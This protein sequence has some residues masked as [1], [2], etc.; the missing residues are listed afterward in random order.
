MKNLFIVCVIL[1]S[2]NAFSQSFFGQ[3]VERLHFGVKAGANF[4]NFTNANFDTE[5][6]VGF[7]A[8]AIVGYEINDHFS[9]E[10]EFLY[11]QQGAKLK[12]N[13]TNDSDIKLSYLSVPI[14]L[15]YKMPMGLFI[16]AGPQVGILID[17]DVKALGIPAGNDFAEKIDGGVTGG[18]GWQFKNGF[19]VSARY[20]MSLTNVTKNT[21]PGTNTDFK[22]SSAQAGVFYIF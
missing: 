10:E 4:S 3:I 5:G 12:G 7:H 6:L 17:E 11:S 9:I 16:E 15:K 14:L 21:Y 2:S 13:F 1:I 19:G 20:Y 8:G 18:I 22:N